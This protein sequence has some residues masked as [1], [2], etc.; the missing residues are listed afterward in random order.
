MRLRKDCKKGLE[1]RQMDASKRARYVTER[2]EKKKKSVRFLFTTIE[3]R[4]T[5]SGVQF[6]STSEDLPL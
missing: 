4:P 2:K 3:E 6:S 1:K 5:C